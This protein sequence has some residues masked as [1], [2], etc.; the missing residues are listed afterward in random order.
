[1]PSKSYSL[2]HS[3]GKLLSRSVK[4]GLMGAGEE[5]A[6]RG[7]EVTVVSPH[8]YKKVPPGVTDI[9]VKSDFV[10]FATKMTDDLLTAKGPPVHP[11][12]E[13]RVGLQLTGW[14]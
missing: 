1:M 13:V 12:G 10:E 7:H 9:V 14:E 6:R 4:I 8:R 11:I 5:L 3:H 2:S